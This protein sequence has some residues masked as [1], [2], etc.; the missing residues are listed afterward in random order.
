MLVLGLTGSLAMG[1]STV[2]SMFGDEGAAVFDADRAVHDLYRGEAVR[3]VEAAFRGTTRDGVVDH[4]RLAATVV[5]DKEALA[6]LE[7]LIHP[8]VAEAENRF[9][10][11]T[12]AGGRRVA[13]LDVP[14][15]LETG[16]EKRVD[17][18]IVVTA[19]AKIQRERGLRHDRMS[20]ERFAALVARQMPDADKRARAHVVIDNGGDLPATR[21]QVEDVLRAVAGMAA[22]R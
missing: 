5:A 7:G 20:D 14:L 1:K 4:A 6:K 12:A 10:A 2:A 18:V 11:A 8:L 17:A 16:G 3:L 19:T 13:V 9:R 22:G 15:L 21:K